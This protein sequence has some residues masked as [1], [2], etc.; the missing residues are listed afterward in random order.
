MVYRTVLT[1]A[2]HEVVCAY[3][4]A[5]ARA[6]CEKVR[7]RQVLLDLL[8]PDGD[9]LEL[10]AT[11]RK[12][13]P[14]ARV[15]V[16]TA[17]GSI[18]RAVQAMRAG[19]VDF[20]VKPF[21]E[22]RLVNAVANAL[23]SAPPPAPE[24]AADEAAEEGGFQGFIGRSPAMADIYRMIHSIGR[25]TATVFITGESGTGKEVCARAIHAMST[26]AAR[27]FVP[28]NCAAIPRDL[29]ESEV[30]GHLKGAF[31]GAL[32]D[33]PGAAAVADGGTLFL[34][35]ICEMDLSLQ[36]KLLRF[37][38]TSTIQPVGAAR[39]VPVDVR[40]VCATNRDP[41]E[42]VRAGR[43]RE[44]LY[45]RLHVVPIHMPPLRSRPE[46]I[47]DIARASL[48][49]F[50][51]E[52]GKS[53]TGFDPQVEDILASRAWP[54]NVR[55]LLNVIRNVVVLHDGTLVQPGMLPTEITL[56]M[57][58]PAGASVEVLREAWAKPTA[59]AASAQGRVDALVG[60][61][62]ADVERELIE[63][64]IEHCGGS[65]PRAAKM[66]ALSPSTVYRKLESWNGVQRRSGTRPLPMAAR[67]AHS[68]AGRKVGVLP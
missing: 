4:L 29:L 23:A 24:A 41:A 38:Q 20:L 7:P 19:A 13:A 16:I 54:G 57:D 42:E 12:D 37:L 28:L 40:I 49:K 62:L 35:E 8:L 46:D 3:S 32:S 58:V 66:L 48:G 68:R 52:E 50:A 1:R 6:H 47:V 56:G 45:Y 61:P 65:I 14:D 63:A 64:T 11:L 18:T 67:L 27:A 17:N 39:P 21:D 5:E 30:F 34:D 10:L 9:G 25:S 59:P 44:D 43:F 60:M 53:F 36:T 15:I 51:A 31:T 26:R 2:G 33:K 22:G 55:Q